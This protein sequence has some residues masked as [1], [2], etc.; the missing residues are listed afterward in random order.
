MTMSVVMTP[1]NVPIQIRI[2]IGM[3]M[4]TV[5]TSLE[6]RFTMRPSGVVSKNDMGALSMD[7]RRLACMMRDASTHAMAMANDWN[8]TKNAAKGK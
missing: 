4:S 2:V 6:K 3:L 5:S 8:N 7:W 1:E